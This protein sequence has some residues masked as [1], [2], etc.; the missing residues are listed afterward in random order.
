M[1]FLVDKNSRTQLTVSGNTINNAK[2]DGI[3]IDLL[4]NARATATVSNNQIINSGATGI[5]A[6]ADNNSQLRLVLDSNTVRGSRNQGISIFSGA[7][8]GTAKIFAS[9]RLNALTGN[10]VSGAAIG[11][12]DA[13]T[14]DAST[15]CLQL[16][17]NT[18]G[19]FALVNNGGTLQVE[20]TLPTNTGNVNQTGTT[21]VPRGTCGF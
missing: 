16:R 9:V 8:G 17:N 12:F 3:D 4:D 18:G 6:D 2:G 10:N 11:D 14:F 5:Q 15:T 20:N 1:N 21:T 7:G 19:N 13:Q